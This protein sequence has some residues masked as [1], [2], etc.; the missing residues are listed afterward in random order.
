VI[1]EFRGLKLYPL[2]PN[3]TRF[4]FHK[5]EKMKWIVR[6]A[7]LVVVCALMLN[8]CAPGIAVVNIDNG[9]GACVLAHRIAG[10]KGARE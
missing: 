7:M 10:S 1:S 4:P 2:C 9:F 8:A 6:S 5:E 3:V